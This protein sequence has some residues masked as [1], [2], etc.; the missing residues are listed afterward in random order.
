[1]AKT[2]RV[3]GTSME[4]ILRAEQQLQREF[5]PSFR[6]WLLT[7]NGQ[8]L[9]AVHIYPVYDERD[10]RKTWDSIIRNYTERWAGWLENFDDR[11][12]D[13]DALLPFAD[14]GN[15]NFYCFDYS[16]TDAMGE[17]PV[18]FWSHETG[19]TA[20]RG[21]SFTEFRNWLLSGTFEYD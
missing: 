13:F 9:G 21:A 6:Q 5:P 2:P 19:D 20:L 11:P 12:G 14:S 10:P 18:V 3:I 1:M 15:G 8:D 4:A 7:H 16:C 17:A